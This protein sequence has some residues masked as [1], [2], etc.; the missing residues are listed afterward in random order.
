MDDLRVG[1]II[2]QVRIKKRWRQA[3]LAAKARLSRATISRIEGG[4]LD[5]LKIA[6]L[7]RVCAA[8][9]I[10]LDLVV[11]YRAGDLD[12]LLNA[13]HSALH[14]A[15]ARLFGDR[16]PAW[17]T[18]HEVSFAIYADRGVIDI[19]A[20]HP[21]RRALLIIELKT[22]VADVN[23]L[24]A[25]TDQRR[26]LARQIVKDRGWDPSTIST[27][28]IV[29]EGRTNRGRVAA[30]RAVL[31]GAFPLDGRSIRT[32]LADP[33]GR[34]DALSFWHG[35]LGSAGSPMI[36]VRRVRPRREP[37]ARGS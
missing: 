31:R 34:V 37:A 9:E 10:R 4:H 25:T 32:W 23:N 6:T 30:H 28:V 8:L 3:D 5:Q 18:E 12:R 36:S 1:T 35:R 24:M 26:R 14:E 21:V 15:V 19:V 16:F 33:I 22:D 7:R 29:T 20:W 2:R 11:Q 13:K 27:W 17:T